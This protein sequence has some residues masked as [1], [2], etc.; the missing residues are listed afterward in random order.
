MVLSYQCF[1]SSRNVKTGVHD[2][3]EPSNV[4][5]VAR[6]C[7]KALL[8]LGFNLLGYKRIK[9][10]PVISKVLGGKDN[11]DYKIKKALLL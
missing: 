5:H 8:P 7:L 2:I 11:L 10:I 6:L 1:W 3:G 4:C 9:L